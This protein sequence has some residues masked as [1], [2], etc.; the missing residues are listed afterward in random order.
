[1]L[2]LLAI[3]L[4]P[5]WQRPVCTNFMHVQVIGFCVLRDSDRLVPQWRHWDCTVCSAG[6]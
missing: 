4:R 2:V 6:E 3:R 5:A 1:V